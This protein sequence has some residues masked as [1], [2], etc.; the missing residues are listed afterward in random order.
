MFKLSQFV[1][2]VYHIREVADLLGVT[3]AT[4]RNYDRDGKMQFERTSGNQRII[5]RENLLKYLDSKGLLVNDDDRVRRDIVYTR[6][7]DDALASVLDS[8]ALDM[9]GKVKDLNNPIV[10]KEIADDSDADR[11][12]LQRLINMVCNDEVN[13][14]YISN[15]DALIKAGYKYLRMMFLSHDTDIVVLDGNY[16]GSG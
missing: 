2:A 7:S 5:S 3:S 8:Q 16:E 15:E 13:K 1:K 14:V 6:V 10:L 4:I 9:I 11:K 12:V